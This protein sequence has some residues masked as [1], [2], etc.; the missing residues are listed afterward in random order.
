MDANRCISWLTI[1]NKGAIPEDLRPLMRNWIFGC[2]ECQTV[3]P[4]VRQF[5]KPGQ[6]RFL[7]FDPDLCAPRLAD[8]LALDGTGFKERFAGT[9]LLRPK[10]K[11]LLRNA[12]VAAGNSGERELLPALE[13]AAQDP[14]PLIAEHARWA[15]DRLAHAT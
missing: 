3:C 8:L 7:R 2:D 5:A 1:E 4:W 12:C 15:L 13:R 11:G 9:P 14:E 10:R 6:A